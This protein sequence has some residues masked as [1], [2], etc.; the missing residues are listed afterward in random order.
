MSAPY[1]GIISGTSVDTIDTAVTAFGDDGRNARVLHACG[2]PI[3]SRLRRELLESAAD[4]RT[5]LSR[6]ARLDVELGHLF[7]EAVLAALQ[8]AGLSPGEIE[9]VGSHGQT[10]RH[11]PEG[12]WPSTTQ[13]GDPNV[14]AHRTGI[15]TVADFRRRDIAAGGQGA[16]LAPA[17]HQAV[18]SRPGSRRAVVNLGGIAN[19]SVLDSTGSDTGEPLGFDCGPANGLL[20][21][22]ARR[23]LEAPLDEGGRW[24]AEG[25]VHGPLL[26]RML[27][28][29]YF[30]KP[31]PKSTGRGYFDE[32]WIDRQIGSLDEPVE[33]R[34]VQR[35]LC[36]LCAATVARSLEDYGGG[37]QEVYLCGGGVHN[38]TLF[39]H[40]AGPS[41][42]AHRRPDGR[43]GDLG[44]L[45]GSGG[46]RLAR[47]VHSRGRPGQSPV[48]DR[49]ERAGRAGGDLPG[50]PVA[51]HARTTLR[52]EPAAGSGE[53]FGSRGRTQIEN[54]RPQ[55]QV[56]VALGFR[57]TNWEPWRS[58]W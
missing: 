30:A 53:P 15:T 58:S 27:D 39:D 22:W 35:T 52:V 4:E 51:P 56:V 24:A 49:C 11:E 46:I 1:L 5:P 19:V 10:I 2:H 37:T 6:V 34:D 33:P 48:G 14:I 9:A 50:S 23:H 17:F 25:A 38:R 3:P 12:G 16:P 29:P 47:E 41:R 31:A 57:T 55:P 28:D 18:M 40:L 8:R 42:S 26:A 43:A 21:A 36:A 54:D 45:R 44:R 32:G 7:A 20:D 13:I